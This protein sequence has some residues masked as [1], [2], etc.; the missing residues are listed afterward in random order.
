MPKRTLKPCSNYSA[1][2][3]MEKRSKKNELDPLIA[4]THNQASFYPKFSFQTNTKSRRTAYKSERANPIKTSSGIVPNTHRSQ[5]GV[6]QI[7]HDTFQLM[8][9]NPSPRKRLPVVHK[10]P[11]PTKTPLNQSTTSS[12]G[13][14]AHQSLVNRRRSIQDVLMP[15]APLQSNVFIS[16]TGDQ[17]ANF[18]HLL[19]RYNSIVVNILKDTSVCIL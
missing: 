15:E 18:F 9:S 7:N 13:Y 8:E 10:P 17:M 19:G 14:K 1:V 2:Q 12:V 4:I 6:Q 16:V 5:N 11:K 3:P